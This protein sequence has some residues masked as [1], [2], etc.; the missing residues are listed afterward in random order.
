[1]LTFAIYT[2]ALIITVL[3]C[4]A[5]LPPFAILMLF[6]GWFRKP[7][8]II[9]RLF[10]LWYGKAIIYI[11]WFPYVRVSYEDPCGSPSGKGI[12]IFNHRSASDPFLVSAIN[13]SSFV[14]VVNHWPMKLPFFGI[15]AEIAGYLD[16]TTVSYEETLEWARERILDDG[17]SIA[18]FPEGTRSGNCTV[19]QF[20]GAFFRIAKA[21]DCPL[22]PVAV[23]GNE[24][25]P[26]RNFRMSPGHIKVR[27]LAP[28]PQD[29]IRNTPPFQLK[30]L[31]RD[32]LIRETGL[33]DKARVM[34]ES[35]T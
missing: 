1:M 32:I 16:I 27:K 23:S 2:Q 22:I 30:N 11:S 17:V 13:D 31:V 4:I 8:Q 14:Q 25:C 35:G 6:F 9:M 3:Y 19:N 34:K 21:L 12:Y 24:N 15:F 18:V 29:I 5:A 28:I 33:M 10:I 7:R 26:D 20:H